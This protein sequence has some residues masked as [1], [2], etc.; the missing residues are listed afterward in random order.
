[1]FLSSAASGRW[2]YHFCLPVGLHL[3]IIPSN[4]ITHQPPIHELLRS[5]H[6]YGF[7]GSILLS[8][9]F[10]QE[11]CPIATTRRK[12]EELQPEG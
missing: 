4:L 5:V 12:S 11:E 10:T 9:L 8:D 3:L 7:G 2:Y 1:M 6:L